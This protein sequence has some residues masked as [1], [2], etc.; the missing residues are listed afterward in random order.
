MRWG[1]GGK[2]GE[3]ERARDRQTG[4][5]ADRQIES[6]KETEKQRQTQREK[7][8]EKE[9]KEE[10]R[11][12]PIALLTSIYS[13]QAWNVHQ[14]ARRMKKMPSSMCPQND[15]MVTLYP[16]VAVGAAET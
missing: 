9:K 5:Q 1:G 4:R 16:R 2:G 3:T 12:V 13:R 15:P 10:K 8:N 11:L 7:T 14:K 6:E